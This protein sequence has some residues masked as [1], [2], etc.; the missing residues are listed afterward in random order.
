MSEPYGL[1]SLARKAWLPNPMSDDDPPKPLRFA[2]VMD[3][4]RVAANRHESF[5]LV[6]VR[7]NAENGP[8]VRDLQEF[9]E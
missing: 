1:W 9:D 6:P 7:F 8:D 3:A 5:R 2:N 4:L